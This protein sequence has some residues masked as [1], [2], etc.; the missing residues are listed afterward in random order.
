MTTVRITVAGQKQIDQQISLDH[1]VHV[2]RLLERGYT[3]W[4]QT[5]DD[6]W[7]MQWLPINPVKFVNRDEPT[8]DIREMVYYA[9]E[10][11][12]LYDGLDLPSWVVDMQTY[13]AHLEP[14]RYAGR[15]TNMRSEPCPS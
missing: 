10:R 11:C 2:I 6:N 5:D 4:A 15:I 8:S 3:V 14:T 1:A 12:D 13:L 9:T 7:S